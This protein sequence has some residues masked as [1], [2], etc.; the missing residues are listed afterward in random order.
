MATFGILA[1]K[2]AAAAVVNFS[3][4]SRDKSSATWV[5]NL[6]AAMNLWRT[7]S[8]WNKVP[9]AS[10]RSAYRGYGK[11]TYPVLT[12]ATTGQIDNIIFAIDVVVPQ[13]VAQ[14]DIDEATARFR[15]AVN[16]VTF[17]DLIKNK[18]APL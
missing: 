12:N 17:T 3:P 6:T 11:L 15:Q 5:E 2:N 10:S 8:V 13:T 14:T 18:T 1:L 4:F 7:W 16:D 9:A